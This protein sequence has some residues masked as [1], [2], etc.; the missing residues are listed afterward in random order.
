MSGAVLRALW[1]HWARHPA[2]LLTLI[3]GLALGTALWSGVQAINAEARASYA[4]AAE[5]LGGGQ[6]TRLVDPAGGVIPQAVFVGLRRAGIAVAPL[7]EG[8]IRAGGGQLDIL[9]IDP[10]SA[11]PALQLVDLTDPGDLRAFL[12]GRAYAAPETLALARAALPGE[13]RAAAG[14]APGQVLMDIGVA[15][16]RLGLQD[17]ISALIVPADASPLSGWVPPGLVTVE[18]A[19][20]GDLDGLT[21][22]FHLNLTA[23]GLLSFA[24]GLF[25]AHGAVGLAFEQRL[26]MFR[27]LRALGVPARMLAAIHGLELAVLALIGGGIG[28]LMGWAVATLLLPGVAGTLGQLYDAAVGARVALRPGWVLS[29]LALALTGAALSGADGVRRLAGLQALA[30]PQPRGWRTGLVRRL[31]WQGRVALALLVL[32]G[33]LAAVADGLVTGFAALAALFLGAALGLP[34]VLDPLLVWAGGR[35]RGPRAAWFWADTAQQLPGLSLALAALMLAL[36]ANIGVGTMVGSFRGTFTGWLDQRLMSEMYLTART[37]AEAAAIRA[38]LS[39]R[40]AAVLPIVSADLTDRPA[41][42]EVFGVADHATYR[43]HWP[44]LQARPD[45]WDALAAG[46]GLLANEQMARRRGLALGDAV[47]LPGGAL[48]VVG[49]YSDYGNPRAQVMVGLDAFAERFPDAVPLRFAV[50]A[51]PSAVPGLMAGLTDRFG[52][53]ASAMIDQAAV[54]ALSR[55]VFDRT[56]AVTGALNVLTLSVAG[57]A[58]W[59]SLLTLAAQRRAQMAPVWA[60]GMSRRLL[61]GLDMG[62]SVV[63]AALTFVLALPLG[64]ALGW[65]LLAVVNVA[66]FGWRL[67]MAVF[68][69]DWARLGGLALLAGALAALPSARAL[70]RTAP[71]E[72]LKVFAHDR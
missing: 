51:D 24:V 15:Q 52:L 40:V 20:R 7:V 27:I 72:M 66:A 13:V 64:L 19:G 44:L 71:A 60:M 11:P 14:L 47:D 16:G 68:P 37:E 21:G 70:A 5:T 32:A 2:Q 63:L 43:D 22:S 56:F 12:A 36:A 39:P 29:G 4:R 26:G 8:R 33:V 25:I 69:A 50:R 54:K 3:L 17:G 53:P 59:T 46:T 58:I 23:F 1:G 62:R 41:R 35:A 57:I 55:D 61:A 18:G 6:T 49:V 67:P 65:M 34:V 31:R 45:A 9:G 28:V 10:L 48:P 30:S 42:A 38:H